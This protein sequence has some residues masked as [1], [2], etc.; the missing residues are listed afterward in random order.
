MTF[1]ISVDQPPNEVDLGQSSVRGQAEAAV[2]KCEDDSK[3][4]FE[5]RFRQRKISVN[6]LPYTGVD[7][8]RVRGDQVLCHRPVRGGVPS[9]HFFQES[10]SLL[11]VQEAL[12]G[13]VLRFR[14]G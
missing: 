12:L 14:Q 11:E 8:F 4:M 2:I 10:Q 7:P 9:H 1:V 6:Q 13:P 3:K 5:I